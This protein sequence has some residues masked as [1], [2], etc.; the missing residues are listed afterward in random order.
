MASAF[1]KSHSFRNVLLK[2]R[3][4]EESPGSLLFLLWK[5]GLWLY[6]CDSNSSP[7]PNPSW[8]SVL[9][10]ALGVFKVPPFQLISSMILVLFSWGTDV[11]GA[12][13]AIPG[14]EPFPPGIY[15]WC[16]VATWWSHL[17]QRLK[18]WILLFPSLRVNPAGTIS[19]LVREPKLCFNFNYCA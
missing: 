19:H 2:A 9:E 15:L 17:L 3:L 13:M 6:V 7:E 10:V 1:Q 5:E 18:H 8:W 16:C 11:T 4:P 14:D 12:W